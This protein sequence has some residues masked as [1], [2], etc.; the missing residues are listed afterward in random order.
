MR[1]LDVVLAWLEK[2][3]E[4]ER[5]DDAIIAADFE[6]DSFQ[7]RETPQVVQQGGGLP[8]G[9]TGATASPLTS[10]DAVRGRFAEEGDQVEI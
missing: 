3:E 5:Q 4:E 8:T 6:A 10:S 1:Q 7:E 9:R 2:M